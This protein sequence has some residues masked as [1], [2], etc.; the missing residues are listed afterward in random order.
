MEV[1]GEPVESVANV[2]RQKRRRSGTGTVTAEHGGEPDGVDCVS[3]T[4]P[5]HRAMGCFESSLREKAK[6]R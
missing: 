5:L 1:H 3:A 4:T 6:Q 2:H